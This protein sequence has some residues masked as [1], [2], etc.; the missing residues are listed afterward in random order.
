MNRSVRS[1][2]RGAVLAPVA[3]AVTVAAAPGVLAD[4]G[5]AGGAV[6]HSVDTI[7]PAPLV[8]TVGKV[9]KRPTAAVDGMLGVRGK[10]GSVKGDGHTDLQFRARRAL[11]A[12]DAVKA[13]W[14][15]DLDNN[16][17]QFV[18]VKSD[19]KTGNSQ[20]TSNDGAKD[21]KAQREC[22]NKKHVTSSRGKADP[23][24]RLA[25]GTALPTDAAPVNGRL[26]RSP[27]KSARKAG[28]AQGAVGRSQARRAPA[29]DA[30]SEAGVGGA[31]RQLLGGVLNKLGNN[32]RKS[33]ADKDASEM[34]PQAPQA[35]TGA[36]K[37]NA[38]RPASGQGEAHAKK[39]ASATPLSLS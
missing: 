37:Q 14:P 9:A 31:L 29:E 33:D 22:D 32:K 26:S 20:E 23:W 13:P 19:C 4:Q 11:G 24:F 16:Q 38:G 8:P 28:T 5:P 1:L 3:T 17:E 36:G 34:A 35:P 7:A 39:S 30:P 10:A 6:R 15:G 18:E 25:S 21:S 27:G 2:L 12:R